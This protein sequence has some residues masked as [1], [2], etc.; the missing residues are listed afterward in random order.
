[1]TDSGSLKVGPLSETRGAAV[2]G[3]GAN[4]VFTATSSGGGQVI[5]EGNVAQVGS[6]GF[7]GGGAIYA[8][9]GATLNV[10]NVVFVSNTA[11]NNSGGAIIANGTVTINA[12]TATFEYNHAGARGGALAAAANSIINADGAVFRGNTAATSGGAV[13]I[14][15]SSMLRAGGILFQNNSNTSTTANTGGGA[16]HAVGGSVID[17]SSGTFE[18]NKQIGGATATVGGGALHVSSATAIIASSTFYGNTAVAN[19]GAVYATGADVNIDI[20]DSWFTS[21]TAAVS[22]GAILVRTGTLQAT[23]VLFTGNAAGGS[24]NGGAIAATS[25]ATITLT[26]VS[27]TGNT[28]GAT[29]NGGAVHGEESDITINVTASGSSLFE[30][31]RGGGGAANSVFMQRTGTLSVNIAAGGVLDMRDPMAS[32]SSSSGGAFLVTQSGGGLWK[33]GGANV[34][35][36]GNGAAAAFTFTVGSGTLHLYRAD[37]A[38]AGTVAAGGIT[39]QPAASVFTLASG[40]RLSVGGGNSIR[41]GNATSGTIAFLAGSIISYDLAAPGNA[42]TP[43]ALLTL[44]A[45]T[46]D[47]FTGGGTGLAFGI[48]VSAY[49]SG[50]FNLLNAGAGT[51]AGAFASLADVGSLTLAGGGNAG[52][53][54][55]SQFSLSADK[56]SLWLTLS[57]ANR[58]LTWTGAGGGDWAGLSWSAAGEPAIAF[59][60]GDIVNLAGAGAPSDTIALA[61]TAT[62]AAIHVSGGRNY[63]LTGAGIA[64]D[65]SAAATTL[66]GSAAATGKLVL[67]ALAPDDAGAPVATAFTGTLDLTGQTGA[68]TFAGGVEI[69]TGALRISSTGQLGATL[70]RLA[71][72][73][74]GVLIAAGDLVFDGGGGDTQ[75][76][77][78]G[79]GKSATLIAEAGKT[80]TFANNATAGNGGAIFSGG[81]LTI[82]ASSTFTGNTARSGGAIHS[83]GTRVDIGAGTLFEDNHIIIGGAYGNGGGAITLRHDDG[84]LLNANNTRFESNTATLAA[85]IEGGVQGGA[86]DAA[87]PPADVMLINVQ[88]SLFL[89]NLATAVSSGSLGY[90]EG[91]AIAMGGVSGTLNA[92]QAVF[93]S[94]TASV[95][96]A[97]AG[98][99]IAQH[100]FGGAI[101]WENGY[102]GLMDAQSGAFTNNTASATG[103]GA[104]SAGG[105]ISFEHAALD[106]RNATFTGNA[107]L[108]S[109]DDASAEGGAIQI[110]DNYADV[111]ASRFDANRA[112]ATGVGGEALAGGGAISY[113][114]D[115]AEPADILDTT[116]AT[117]TNNTAT[118]ADSLAVGGAILVSGGQIKLGATATGTSLFSGNTIRGANTGGA[119]VADSVHF[120]MPWGGMTASAHVETGGLLDMRDPM[121]AG[122]DERIFN[123]ESLADMTPGALV[124]TK[125]GGGEW[126]L[127]GSSVLDGSQFPG[128]PANTHTIDFAVNAGTLRLT[129]GAAIKAGAVATSTFTLAAGATLRADGGNTIS[130]RSITL[131]A[132]SIITLD[133]AAANAAANTSASLLTLNAATLDAGGWAQTL[134]L[135]NLDS[136]TLGAASGDSFGLIALGGGGVFTD[137][138]LATLAGNT[139]LA[140][141]YSLIPSADFTTLLLHYEIFSASGN[142]ISLWTNAAADNA[143]NATSVNWLA[144]A[145]GATWQAGDFAEFDAGGAGGPGGTTVSVAAAGVQVAGMAVTGG[146]YT[147]SGGAIASTTVTTLTAATA[148]TQKLAIHAGADVTIANTINFA[149]GLDIAATGALTLADS[150]SIAPAMTIANDGVFAINRAAAYTLANTITGGGTLA[151]TGAGE[152]TLSVP[153]AITQNVVSVNAGKL[154]VGPAALLTVTGALEVA[155]GATL[156]VTVGASPSVIAGNVAFDTAARLDITGYGAATSSAY[157][158]VPDAGVTVIHTTNGIT[159][160]DPT[161]VTITGATSVDFLKVSARATATDVIVDTVLTWNLAD[162][163]AHGDFTIAA[164][165]TFTINVP[166]ADNT[167]AHPGWD[168]SSLTKL[169]E[170][171]LVLTAANTHTGATTIA[172]G[173]LTNAGSLGHANLQN[174]ALTNTGSITLANIAGGN[175]ANNA[176]GSVAVFHQTGGDAANAGLITTATLN[177]A[178]AATLTNTGTLGNVNLQNGALTNAGAIIGAATIGATGT[179]RFTG[180]DI[181]AAT[182]TNAG[183]LDF[184]STAAHT[185][186]TAITG[187]GTIAKTGDGDLALANTVSA[188][189]LALSNGRLDIAGSGALALTGTLDITNG[190]TLGITA[191]AGVSVTAAAVNFNTTGR[192][193]ITGYTAVASSTYPSDSNGARTLIHTI[194]GGISGFDA[195]NIT[196]NGATGVDYLRV[197]AHATA[198]DVIVDTALTWNLAD[199]SAHGD[200]TIAAGQTFTI[201]APLADNTAAHPGWDGSSLTKLGEGTLILTAGNTRTGATTI[202]GGTL[203]NTGVIA[204]APVN[205]AA[206]GALT[207]TGSITAGIVSNGALVNTTGANLATLVQTAG[208]VTNAG[209]ITTATLNAAAF[210]VATATFTN[211]GTLGNADLQIGALTNTGSIT[212]AN[213]SG[214]T[215]ANATG[216]AVGT[217]TQTAGDV[218]NAG[219]IA[220]A[221]ITAAAAATA[222]ATLTNTGTLATLVQTAGAVANTGVLATAVTINGGT[223]VNHGVMN[224]AATIGANGTLLFNAGALAAPITNNGTL[225]FANAAAFTLDRVVSGSGALVKTGAGALTIAIAQTY[226]GETTIHKGA[227]VTGTLGALAAS[228][229]VDLAAAATLDLAGH[230]QT[231]RHLALANGARV[232]FSNAGTTHGTLTL[233]ELSGDGGAFTMRADPAAGAHDTLALTGTHSGAHHVD[234]ILASALTTPLLLVNTDGADGDATFSGEAEYGLDAWSLERAAEGWELAPDGASAAGDVVFST[235]AVLGSEWF[236]GLDSL[237]LRMGDLRATPAAQG[238]VWMRASAYRLKGS[239]GAPGDAFRQTTWTVTAGLDAAIA[240]ETGGALILG[241]F[242]QTG[243]SDRT[244]DHFGKSDTDNAAAGLYG[245][246]LAPDGWFIDATLKYDRYKNKL[247]ARDATAAPTTAGYNTAAIGLSLETGRRIP[248][249]SGARHWIEPSVQLA[250]AWIGSA[251]YVTSTGIHVNVK[252]T[253]AWQYRAQLR[254]GASRGKWTPYIKIA[255]AALNTKGG[256][257][258]ASDKEN[259][260]GAKSYTADFDGFRFEAGAGASYLINPRRQL[261]IDYEYNKST[262][263]ERPWSITLGYRILW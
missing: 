214:G 54:Y 217:L 133:L 72:T 49:A 200:F 64:A 94:N 65:A 174:G 227:L 234:I 144:D 173:A 187:G 39:L 141:N 126:R 263:L 135:L 123:A 114:G 19:G 206:A 14:N 195:A 260:A 226:T 233:A 221:T 82:G 158:F 23:N 106:A 1:L 146:T 250:T 244:Y 113:F 118:S 57:L 115:P 205:I 164:G 26:D 11:S 93:T 172:A 170:G 46:M 147:F 157:P 8:T 262:A 12:R 95:S 30:D 215:F 60:G 3:G 96:I 33:L 117:F 69:D 7:S 254:A 4:S 111:R 229:R 255:A 124:I 202:T 100:A 149:N 21:N 167:A 140:A 90:A 27:F 110:S 138:N 10:N 105:A 109:G 45:P 63:A 87:Y 151:K 213:I 218:T 130:A 148:T 231:L 222:T 196:I 186:D 182:V 97:V 41:A 216:G 178:A 38:G 25:G 77:T 143:W 191:G 212:L 103:P 232:H 242:I 78:V 201:N 156:G 204:G 160:F 29:G 128:A 165:Q 48:E 224:A 154:I 237:H 210:A 50:S 240:T 74:T 220:T 15:T 56:T 219:L 203:I 180:G 188:A 197:N 86:I 79:A 55:E 137:V 145:A 194:G 235:A 73:G 76:L 84:V 52:T 122:Y 161:G 58:V 251:A 241:G 245:T 20:R 22:G 37:E 253:N 61:T 132:A 256:G 181:T 17:V 230:P 175:F 108:A 102:G 104:W 183:L 92:Q 120:W 40:A 67:G 6:S 125:T 88:S 159:G 155:T 36:A 236:H 131:D 150:G 75:R 24:N 91:G 198:T 163:N 261:Y 169:G 192:L 225:D 176:G 107:S 246:L 47:I 184:A 112:E 81:D 239:P 119:A 35:N 162:G 116:D 243:R 66:S 121:S 80:I 238:D 62:V 211:T 89:N 9:T 127:S 44:T 249:T 208:T 228:S 171:T 2:S 257:I 53:R 51:G 5:F 70:S 142:N 28:S 248:L 193:D 85:G 129:Q 209:L 16:I 223:L 18:Y 134:N 247:D 42:A 185:L 31:N 252:S 153:G 177:A 168:G 258:R 136:L 139:T 190:S 59:A 13:Y 43:S 166:L 32:Q 99:D 179:L 207:N 71:F 101:S 68:N 34:F 199:G 98:V 259:T 83:T 152:L 189:A